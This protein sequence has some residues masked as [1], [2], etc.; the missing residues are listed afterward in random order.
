MKRLDTL[1]PTVL[2][3]IH[4]LPEAVAEQF[5]RDAAVELA[6]RTG[7][8]RRTVEFPIGSGRCEAR[9]DAHALRAAEGLDLHKLVEVQH[10]LCG[11]LSPV[12]CINDVKC[13][14]NSYYYE[15]SFLTVSATADCAAMVELV[16]TCIPTPD[17]CFVPDE[18]ADVY[19]GIME[20]C[21]IA[22]A[23]DMPSADWYNPN[24]AQ[25]RWRRWEREISRVATDATR[26]RAG[27]P[28]RPRPVRFI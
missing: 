8:V 11:K 18:I 17:T 28:M 15:P 3:S 4:G 9:I 14:A 12:R 21:V 23:L 25:M 27:G 1:T 7:V 10:P 20:N 22:K 6:Q 16:F 5:M 19:A 13:T 2:A 24:A 26:H